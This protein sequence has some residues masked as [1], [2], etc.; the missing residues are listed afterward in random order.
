MKQSRY[1][2]PDRKIEKIRNT[3]MSVAI[4]DPASIIGKL[5]SKFVCPAIAD[6]IISPTIKMLKASKMML[7]DNR[8]LILS[9]LPNIVCNCCTFIS[10]RSFPFPTVDVIFLISFGKCKRISV[11]STI[12]L[13]EFRRTVLG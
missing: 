11:F 2:R 5:Q 1:I 13:H 10:N 12:S 7:N 9:N 8:L 4:I 3:N 6:P